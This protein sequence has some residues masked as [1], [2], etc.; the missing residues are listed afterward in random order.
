MS[1][2]IEIDAH[3]PTLG[4]NSHFIP[5]QD[6]MEFGTGGVDDAQDPDIVYHEYGHAI[7]DNQVPN[8]GTSHEGGSAGEGFGDYWAASL[9]DDLFAP[10]LGAACVGPWNATA[11]NPYTGALGSGC[12][13]RVDGAKNYPQD[14]LFEVHDDGEMWSAA[15]WSLRG[16]LGAALVDPLVIKSHTFLTPTAGFIDAA[17]AMLSADQALHAGAHAASI[18]NALKA[19]GLPRTGVP[20][21]GGFNASAPFHCETNHPYA[22]LEY[23]ECRFT[24][25]GATRLRFHFAT[26]NTE[27]ELD[28]AYISDAD[29]RQVQA[30]SGTPFGPG[31]GFSAAVSGDTIVLRFK[32]DPSIPGPGFVIDAVE[33]FQSAPIPAGR[34]PD[35]LASRTAGDGVSATWSASCAATDDDYAVY[36]GMLGDYVSHLPVVCSTSGLRHSAW[37]SLPGSRWFIITPRNTLIEGSY[38]RRG[39]TS[40]RPPSSDAC[41]AQSIAPS[42]P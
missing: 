22:G 38:G 42:C 40:E 41:A 35:L 25:P 36:E 19:R 33:Y 9:T 3:D 23:K 18:E 26:F 28:Y 15:L 34:V 2:S 6:V 12:Q 5:S 7:Q 14:M 11:F 13:R 8:F 30:L 39:D 27:D 16:T 17:D 10:D 20:A 1:F 4:D 29:F 37:D 21:P 32:A 24:Q 31:G